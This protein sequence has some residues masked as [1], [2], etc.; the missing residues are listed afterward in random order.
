M[1]SRF[2]TRLGPESHHSG[3]RELQA[4]DVYFPFSRVSVPSS[5]AMTSLYM[6]SML[7]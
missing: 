5:V 2:W 6:F 1:T 3:W 7:V 4:R